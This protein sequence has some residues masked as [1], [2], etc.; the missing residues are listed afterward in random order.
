MIHKIPPNIDLDNT[1]RF[2]K[3]LDLKVRWTYSYADMRPGKTDREKREKYREAAAKKMT[4][5]VPD[6]LW[7]AFRISVE[8]APRLLDLDNVAKLI[9]DAF[10][11][12]RIGK[13]N[14]AHRQVGLYD[15]DTL[16]YVRAIQM[17]G[18]PGAA[19]RTRIEVFA[20]IKP[21]TR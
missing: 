11:R 13:D 1:D 10:C 19:D 4:Y 3:V 2:S 12:N 18:A 16:D 17:V 8:K 20:C 6:A 15:D 14:S 9:V 7:W 21:E 5:P